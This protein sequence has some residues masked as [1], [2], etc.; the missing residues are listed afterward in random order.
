MIA[1]KV[2]R[3]LRSGRDWLLA[4]VELVQSESAKWRA[5]FTLVKSPY[6]FLRAMGLNPQMAIGLIFAG[7]VAGGGVVV[8]ETLLDGPSFRA[9]DSGLYQSPNDAPIFYDPED[10]TLHLIIDDTPIGL[11]SISNATIGTAYVGSVLPP[12]ETNAVIVGGLPASG[13]IPETF[14][15]T[16]YLLIERGRCTQLILDK[17]DAHEFNIKYNASDG[18]SITLRNGVMR[19]FSITGGEY[20]EREMRTPAGRY[21]QIKVHPS[22][23]KIARVIEMRFTGLLTN[24]GPCVYSRIQAAV[25][26]VILN[27]TGNG[28]GFLLKDL[29]VDVSCVICNNVDNREIS[30][31]Q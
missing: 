9:G 22:E 1:L 11:V 23:G 5:A 28:D 10:N 7:T 18:Q 27:T 21:D 14:I 19:R 30:V 24:G 3:T 17:I 31:S 26:D 13:S 6:S 29:I 16:E 2:Y 4:K 8:K 15:R 25:V 12:G 20:L